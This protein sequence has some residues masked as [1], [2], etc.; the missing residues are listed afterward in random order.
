MREEEF[1]VRIALP[2]ADFRLQLLQRQ[3]A[4]QRIRTGAVPHLDQRFIRVVC[5]RITDFYD[6]L[7]EAIS[8]SVI[9]SSCPQSLPG[10]GSFPVSQLFS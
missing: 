8:S 6:A 9:S 5:I 7:R 1:P 4:F 10:S 3:L 2:F